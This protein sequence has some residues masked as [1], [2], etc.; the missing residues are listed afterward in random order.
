MNREGHLNIVLSL[1]GASLFGAMLYICLNR[2]LAS[3]LQISIEDHRDCLTQLPGIKRVGSFTVQHSTS[4]EQSLRLMS[5]D[6]GDDASPSLFSV[7]DRRSASGEDLKALTNASG[8]RSHVG[9]LKSEQSPVAASPHATSQL[10]DNDATSSDAAIS[11]KKAKTQKR[12]SENMSACATPPLATISS[13]EKKPLSA[14]FNDNLAT[15]NMSSS[16]NSDQTTMNILLLPSQRRKDP[17]FSAL[18]LPAAKQLGGAQTPRSAP[19]PSEDRPLSLF[20]TT[21]T[22][23]PPCPPSGTMKDV[24]SEENAAA[25][26]SS[27]SSSSSTMTAATRARKGSAHSIDN[28]KAAKGG[29]TAITGSAAP[30]NSSFGRSYQSIRDSIASRQ[31]S[32]QFPPFSPP[33]A[34]LSQFDDSSSRERSTIVTRRSTSKYLGSGHRVS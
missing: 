2:L 7:R 15:L 5:L 16:R 23:E 4:S 11:L 31:K 18:E 21:S 12:D 30:L 9:R 28:S 14:V 33:V 32:G 8:G 3:Y 13:P 19:E 1:I 24:G 27:S 26:N 25:E 17:A 20:S 10:A 34:P 29:P 22:N 6:E